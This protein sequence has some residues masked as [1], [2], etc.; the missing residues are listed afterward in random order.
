[1]VPQLKLSFIGASFRMLEP[2]DYSTGFFFRLLHRK[3]LE[4]AYQTNCPCTD[5]LLWRD[6][7]NS[8]FLSV[9]VIQWMLLYKQKG[10]MLTFE[11]RQKKSVSKLLTT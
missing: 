4:L 10:L 2:N 7:G 8:F 6:A 3:A 11:T 1:M 5:Q 9:P